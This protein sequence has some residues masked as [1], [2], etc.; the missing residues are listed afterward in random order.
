MDGCHLEIIKEGRYEDMVDFCRRYYIPDEPIWNALNHKWDRTTEELILKSL[1]QN[2]TIA[3]VSNST[4]EIVGAQVITID[5]RYEQLDLEKYGNGPNAIRMDIVITRLNKLNNFYDF[6]GTDEVVHLWQ[7]SVKTEERCKGIGTKV[8][9]TVIEC[10]K[11]INIGPVVIRVEGSSN[12]SKKIFDKLGFN[13]LA[14]VSLIDYEVNDEKINTGE[15]KSL[16]L[17]GKIVQ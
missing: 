3:Y 14:E 15:H 5:N 10:I 9:K 6:Y 2:L 11:N 16:I 1:S 13:Y 17:Y 8:K 7:L 4:G 12:Y